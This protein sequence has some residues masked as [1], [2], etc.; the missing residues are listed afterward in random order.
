MERNLALRVVIM[1]VSGCGKST[2]GKLLAQRMAA[3]P[4]HFMPES[5]L[6]SQ[7]ARLPLP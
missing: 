6:D 7:L 3:R 5:L 2:V 1:G 4:G